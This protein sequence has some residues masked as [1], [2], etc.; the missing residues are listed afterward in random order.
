MNRILVQ[1][2][3]YWY[4][5]HYRYI[6]PSAL[7]KKTVNIWSQISTRLIYARF[8]RTQ[9]RHGLL[10][11]THIEKK[12]PVK[13]NK[14]LKMN[15]PPRHNTNDLHKRI[16]LVNLEEFIG[17]LN[18]NY[19]NKCRQSSISIINQLVEQRLSIK[20]EF[21][22]FCT[23]LSSSLSSYGLGLANVGKEIGSI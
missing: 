7:L 15:L 16:N 18:I 17:N 3:H 5:H 6:Y 10:V 1:S 11:R 2:H 8:L 14:T 23:K 22:I 9:R 20:H 13:Q 12:L 4:Y 19:A 21:I